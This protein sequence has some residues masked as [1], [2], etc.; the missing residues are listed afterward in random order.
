LGSSLLTEVF[1]IVFFLKYLKRI[2]QV[3]P[4]NGAYSQEY[5]TRCSL[6]FS[7]IQVT[8][9]RPVP[10]LGHHP[11]ARSLRPAA[12]R[13]GAVHGKRE[14]RAAHSLVFK[15][16]EWHTVFCFAD[17]SHAD[18]FIALFGGERFDPK[19]ERGVLDGRG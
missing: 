5:K 1:V 4:V 18:Q 16:D 14:R 11:V 13:D 8:H 12:R 7:V 10:A 17:E 3:H 19:S 2:S 6:I 9:C 15:D